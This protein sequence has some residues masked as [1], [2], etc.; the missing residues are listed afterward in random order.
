[1]IPATYKKQFKNCVE[2]MLFSVAASAPPGEEDWEREG[3]KDTPDRVWRAYEHM[4]SGYG[5]DIPNLFTTFDADGYDQI[6]IL[7]DIEVFSMCE[8]HILPFFGRAHVAYIPKKKVIGVSKLARL[9]DAYARRLQIQERLGNQVTDALM[10]YLE[11]AGA[12][13]IIDA[14]HMCTRMRGVEKQHSSMKTSS[15][16][17]AFYS[18]PEARAELMMLLN[19][20]HSL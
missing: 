12:A 4:F 11:P 17:G 10:K 3:L 5:V 7:R 9:V 20:N 8:H 6:V 18:K 1:M 13:C 15:L 2:F 19:G 14:V 16:K